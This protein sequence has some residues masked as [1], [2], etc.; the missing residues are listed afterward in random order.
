[1]YAYTDAFDA[2][3]SDSVKGIGA[4][5]AVHILVWLY[6]AHGE[7]MHVSDHRMFDLLGPNV[8][9]LNLICQYAGFTL[10]NL[11]DQ[12]KVALLDMG[13]VPFEIW[14]CKVMNAMRVLHLHKQPS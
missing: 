12:V 7:Y 4:F 8:R 1:M 14:S 6:N 2:L 3:A 11:Y 10:K 9:E 5:R 13:P